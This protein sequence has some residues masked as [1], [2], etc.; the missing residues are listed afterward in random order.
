MKISL[1]YCGGADGCVKLWDVHCTKGQDIPLAT[2]Y[3]DNAI[4][5]I[6]I[7]EQTESKMVVRTLNDVTVHSILEEA[8]DHVEYC[9]TRSR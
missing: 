2:L 7:D 4:N 3:H 5:F 9:L 1:L 8:L 6:H